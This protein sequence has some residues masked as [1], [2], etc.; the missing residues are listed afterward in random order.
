MPFVEINGKTIMTDIFDYKS[1]L[2]I[3][4]IVA[5]RLFL[6]SYMTNLLAKRNKIT[7][8]YTESDQWKKVIG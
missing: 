3:L 1:P 5:D 4:E 2:G 8:E 6:K 7:K